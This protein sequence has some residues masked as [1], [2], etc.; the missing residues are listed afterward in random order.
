MKSIFCHKA[1]VAPPAANTLRFEFSNQSYN[2]VA[3]GVGSSGTWKRCE[4]MPGNVWDWTRNNRSWN[5]AFDEALQNQ[6]T[7]GYIDV[8]DA[9]DTSFVTDMGS[10]FRR[11]TAIRSL[12]LFNTSNVTSFRLFASRCSIERIPLYDTGKVTNFDF[13]FYFC[14][15]LKSIPLFDTSKASSVS[16]MFQDC[17]EVESGALDL[18]NQMSTQTTPPATHDLTFSNCGRDTATGAAELAQI[19]VSW[20]GTMPNP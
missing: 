11:C 4:F 9:G 8:I 7:T 19:P 5:S 6:V 1:K 10:L 15:R 14:Q 18:Y 3:N 17:F 13:A 12:C 20:G 16:F 2:P